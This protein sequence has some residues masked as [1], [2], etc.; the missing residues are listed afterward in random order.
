MSGST[1][2]AAGRG[3][4]CTYNFIVLTDSIEMPVISDMLLYDSAGESF[5]YIT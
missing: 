3:I 2:G 1:G 4:L 5:S